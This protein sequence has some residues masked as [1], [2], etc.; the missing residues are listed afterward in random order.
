MKKILY[1]SCIF[2]LTLLSF[3][4]SDDG[5]SGENP[6]DQAEN[7]P[8]H[9]GSDLLKDHCTSGSCETGQ[10][11]G[12]G[13]NGTHCKDGKCPDGFTC[14]PFEGINDGLCIAKTA[15][16]NQNC[17]DTVTDSCGHAYK[18]VYIH[19]LQ[20]MAENMKC[21]KGNYKYINK[22][23]SINDNGLLYDWNSAADRD[24]C[25]EGWRLPTREEASAMLAVSGSTWADSSNA[26]RAASWA[27][28]KDTYGFSALPA[29]NYISGQYY[30]QNEQSFIWTSSDLIDRN[31]DD[32]WYLRI[33]PGFASILYT[34]KK[35]FFSARCVKPVTLK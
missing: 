31:E 17:N 15:D 35:C 3:A 5:N 21:P 18:T 25:P 34:T 32:A 19:G 33:S 22:D 6:N 20:W 12:V 9:D 7:K 28:G 26:L 24:F 27:D 30:F 4:C 16:C 11:P 1:L 23:E 10:T 29:G 13:P 8:V 14:T 2:S